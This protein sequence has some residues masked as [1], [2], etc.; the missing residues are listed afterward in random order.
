MTAWARQS[1]DLK[2]SWNGTT[3]D[4]W[5]VSTDT[6]SNPEHSHWAS[7]LDYNIV[8]EPA[9]GNT[10][11]WPS[12]NP[13]QSG[14]GPASRH[15][16]SREDVW[17]FK[18]TVQYLGNSLWVARPV[19]P[20]LRCHSVLLFL[21]DGA[22][23]C[24]LGP[25]DCG[26]PPAS[27]Y[28]VMGLDRRHLDHT[29]LTMVTSQ[30]SLRYTQVKGVSNAA[31]DGAQEPKEAEPSLST[32]FLLSDTLLSCETDDPGTASLGRGHREKLPRVIHPE[33]WRLSSSKPVGK[34]YS[35]SS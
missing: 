24:S 26:K 13:G 23:L 7:F 17:W 21:Q 5:K 10:A 4:Y 2:Q 32:K 6:H 33:S 19:N 28:Q 11:I 9:Q 31:Q 14:I 1:V 20:A 29:W 30:R 3:V 16:W 15:V 12:E 35:D 22:L 18:K 25:K 8:T 27:L 34:L